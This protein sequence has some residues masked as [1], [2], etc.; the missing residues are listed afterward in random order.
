MNLKHLVLAQAVA[1]LACGGGGPNADSPSS[2]G[3]PTPPPATSTPPPPSSPQSY[4]WTPLE[5]KPG[6]LVLRETTTNSI[7]NLRGEAIRGPLADEKR[8]LTQ[9]P[10]VNMFWFAFS[11]YFPGATVW[12][13]TEPVRQA[14]LPDDKTGSIACGG[15]RDCIPSLPNTG[16]PRGGLNFTNA[17]AADASYLRDD[18][19][20][21]GLF[22]NG[23]A[24]AYPHNILWWHEIANDDI[25]GH[26]VSVTMCPLTGSAVVWGGGDEG[27][28]FGV[29]GNLFNSNL[30]MYDHQTQSLWPQLFM[31]AVSG[32]ARGK[33]LTMFPFAEMTWA[34]WRT[35]HP[36]TVV[37]SDRT[38]AS[39]SY[40]SYP[41]GDYRVNHGDTFRRTSPEPDGRYPNKNMVFALADRAGGVARGFVHSDLQAQ[42]GPSGALLDS[43]AG[44]PIVVVWE[45]KSQLVR[46]FAAEAAAGLLSFV[47][48]PFAP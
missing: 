20:V 37:L 33:W 34:R 41:Y 28:T 46:A 25:A 31:G 29:S 18:D 39:R 27:Y 24:R 21:V 40:S 48:E 30:V 12:G 42:G 4:T 3:L 5:P 43:F 16:P 7:F 13:S 35:L 32:Q 14:S 22:V 17:N 45:S 11:V 8:I 38:G 47:A 26:K 2:P 44:R 36:D 19:L 23:V 15:G 6:E 10:G 1:A 9:L